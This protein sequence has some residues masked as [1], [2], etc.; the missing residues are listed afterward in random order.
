MAYVGFDLDETL[1]RFS[2]AHYYTLFLQPK[3][4]VYEGVWSGLYGTGFIQEPIPLSLSL[5][6][7]LDSAFAKFIH[8]VAQKELQNPPLGL[9]RPSMID[10]VKRLKELKEEGE[11]KAVVIYSNNGNLALLHLAG[12]MLETIANAPN[13]FCNYIHWFHPLRERE[14]TY[15]KPGAAIKTL[16]VLKRAFQ[17]G[18]CTPAEIPLDKIYFFDDLNPPHYDLLYNL[19]D[20]Y[21]QIDP[22]KYDAEFAPLDEC[23]IQVM[24]ESGLSE[25]K[26]YYEYI[27]PIIGEQ[28]NFQDILN[29]INQDK[30]GMQ[31]SL[32]KPNNTR[33]VQRTQ[34]LFPNRVTKRNFLQS[35][36]RVRSLERKQNLGTA[37]TEGEQESLRTAQNVVTA[38]EQQHPNTGGSRKTKKQRRR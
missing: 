21:I 22:Y 24:K 29:V 32:L 23:F 37:L 17:T 15:R 1:G 25:N 18:L 8:C 12:K 38:Y 36:Q 16:S 11:V 6:A 35:L 26:E 31:R 19:E 30:L 7:E 20:R 33:L 28:K 10:F 27:A 34:Q 13:L 5:K 14:V 3:T 2:V 9:L 4:V